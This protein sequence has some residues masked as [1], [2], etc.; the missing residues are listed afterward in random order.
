M[1]RR[2]LKEYF[3]LELIYSRIDRQENRAH[4]PSP[5][6]PQGTTNRF[7]PSRLTISSTAFPCRSRRANRAAAAE[8]S[9]LPRRSS[10]RP[11]PNSSTDRIK[12]VQEGIDGDHEGEKWSTCPVVGMCCQNVCL[13]PAASS[14]K[15]GNSHGD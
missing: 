6:M 12:G 8:T 3:R 1:R 5:K 4:K 14:E 13:R 10:A 2:I 9:A 15:F 11:R 7:L